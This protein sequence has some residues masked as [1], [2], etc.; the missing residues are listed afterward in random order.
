M[1]RRPRIHVPGAFYHVTLRGNH[2]QSIFFSPHDRT[3]LNEIVASGVTRCHARL[4]AYCW[5][6]NHVHMLLQV[7]DVP[8]GAL[9]QRVASRFARAVQSGL[10]TTGH[11]FENR[12]HA[13]LVTADAHLLELIRYIHL[14][15]V[16][17]GLVDRP[18]AYLWSSHHAYAGDRE[19]SWLT[20]DFLLDM[21]TSRPGHAHA[22][23]CA[24]MDTELPPETEGTPAATPNTIVQSCSD[25]L[26]LTDVAR[27]AGS[28]ETLPDLIDQ[29]VAKF[30]VTR[31]SLLSATRVR[32]VTCARSWIAQIAVERGIASISET[33]RCLGRDESSLRKAVARRPRQ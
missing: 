14:N 1:P 22:A 19:E 6:T 7:R 18:G 4:H 25:G 29:A 11:L 5:M 33:A 21:F 2:R 3:L 27:C 32:T 12:Y 10:N 16:R 31:E 15:P 24:F 23:Y 26:Q 9:V 20:T 13:V 28:S 30:G 8:L 17:A